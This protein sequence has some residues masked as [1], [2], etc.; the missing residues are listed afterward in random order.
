[1]Y[2]WFYLGVNLEKATEL[3]NLLYLIVCNLLLRV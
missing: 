1:M 2:V 3:F